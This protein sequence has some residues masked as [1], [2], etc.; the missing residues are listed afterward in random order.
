MKQGAP[1]QL[2]SSTGELRVQPAL[3]SMQCL[4]HLSLRL[5]TDTHLVG[6]QQ[7]MS[8]KRITYMATDRWEGK[9]LV[10]PQKLSCPA[11]TGRACGGMRALA[12]DPCSQLAAPP[13][14]FP[15]T[16][17]SAHCWPRC[18]DPV[19]PTLSKG[20]VQSIECI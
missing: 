6:Q 10:T 1:V 11:D 13:A 12:Q 15:Q 17:R 18:P 20:C 19:Q 7:H 2:E 8:T 16:G 14:D 5:L 3:L 4:Q 9:A